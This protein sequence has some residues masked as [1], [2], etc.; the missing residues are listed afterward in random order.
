MGA[1]RNWALPRPLGRSIDRLESQPG[2]DAPT[3]FSFLHRP[4][5]RQIACGITH[6]NEQTHEI[7]RTN[8]ARLSKGGHTRYAGPCYCP[9]IGDGIVR[10]AYGYRIEVFRAE[11]WMIRTVYPNGISTR[12][13]SMFRRP[14]FVR[15]LL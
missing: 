14:M 6:T 2:D 1:V 3:M 8:L 15:S 12:C 5:A 9:S 4:F 11:G 7:I 10:F 13:R